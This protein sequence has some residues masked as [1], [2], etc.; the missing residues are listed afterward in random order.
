MASMQMRGKRAY[1]LVGGVLFLVFFWGGL[2]FHFPGKQLAEA[3]RIRLE[4]ATGWHWEIVPVRLR[5]NG[6]GIS[7]LRGSRVEG[8]SPLVNLSGVNLS[9]LE[10]AFGGPLLRARIG[11]N[12]RVRVR[13]PWRRSG[14][15]DVQVQLP[16]EELSLA[17]EKI[18]IP[19]LSGSLE[20]QGQVSF[21]SQNFA[22]QGWL[23]VDINNLRFQGLRVLGQEIPAMEFSV[24]QLRIESD[25]ALKIRQFRIEGD[26]QGEVSGNIQWNANSLENSV[27]NLHAQLTPQQRWL[28]Q[29]GEL[30]LMINSFLKQGQLRLHLEGSLAKP[31][32]HAS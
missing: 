15:M 17:G 18:G 32:W 7:Q 5:W 10:A 19:Q 9:L 28:E 14:M 20:V 2:A 4:D 6:L 24:V 8:E 26:L 21:S 27:L 30:R 16:L 11:E 22:P 12:G 29:L 1:V 13:L 31:R 25:S 3:A 23:E